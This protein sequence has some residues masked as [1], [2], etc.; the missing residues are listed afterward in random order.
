MRGVQPELLSGA[1]K[2]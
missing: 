1:E 2:V